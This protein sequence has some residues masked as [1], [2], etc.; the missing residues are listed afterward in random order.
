ML[1]K[2]IFPPEADITYESFLDRA[3]Q[4]TASSGLFS[5]AS[6][7]MRIPLAGCHCWGGKEAVAYKKPRDVE[8]FSF[9]IIW[10]SKWETQFCTFPVAL[11]SFLCH[12]H[13]RWIAFDA[14][15][16]IA[17]PE[18]VKISLDICKT[19]YDQN[20]HV[21]DQ[22]M[23]KYFCTLATLR[24]SGSL[25]DLHWE[26]SLT[27]VSFHILDLSFGSSV[28]T[29]FTSTMFLESPFYKVQSDDEWW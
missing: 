1:N 22:K 12:F 29:G 21:Y 28:I 23:Y 13:R 26:G 6:L 10:P 8:T 24:F 20:L 14:N 7:V 11:R 5:A 15:A 18:L 2:E 3:K 25:S 9:I 17:F 16:S 19:L 27:S 4:G